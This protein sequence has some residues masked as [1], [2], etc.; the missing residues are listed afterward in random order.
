MQDPFDPDSMTS[1]QRERELAEALDAG[2]PAP[3]LAQ[4]ARTRT[5][6]LSGAH[7]PRLP[8]PC[9]VLTRDF[10]G[11]LVRVTVLDEGFEFA[12]RVHRSFSA[13]AVRRR[14]PATLWCSVV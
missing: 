6:A 12:G 9:T 14:R 1:E 4:T 2:L 3:P 7:D 11:R 8:M 13:T 10:K 5:H